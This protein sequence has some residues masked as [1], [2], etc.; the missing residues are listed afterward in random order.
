MKIDR[1]ALQALGEKLRANEPTLE[2]RRAKLL[3]SALSLAELAVAR[4]FKPGGDE[5]HALR[6]VAQYQVIEAAE[7]G[8]GA[9][10]RETIITIQEA[11]VDDD[12]AEQAHDQAVE[13][14]DA[15]TPG[16]H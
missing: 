13:A 12:G 2:E 9:T 6:C 10:V 16:V 7:K 4:G 1:E 3:A 14:A 5:L 15:R 8:S 11:P